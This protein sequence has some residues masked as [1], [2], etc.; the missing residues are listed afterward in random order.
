M[1]RPGWFHVLPVA[2]AILSLAGAEAACA[3]A[4]IGASFGYSHLSISDSDGLHASNDVVGIPNLQDWGQPGMR[5]GYLFPNGNWALNADLGLFFRSGTV[6]PDLT[7]FEFL[8]QVQWSLWNGGGYAPYVSLGVGL[9]HD[10]ADLGS[11]SVGAT[12]P[13]FGGG[14]G[15]RKSVSKGQGFLRAEVQ[16][17]YLPENDKKQDPSSTVI[18]LETNEFSVKLGFDLVLSR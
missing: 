13:T 9:Q 3:Q 5:V 6:G 17:G 8:P 18:F 16:Y 11:K 7:A 4:T 10:T 2:V 1:N 15:V 14:V 12:R